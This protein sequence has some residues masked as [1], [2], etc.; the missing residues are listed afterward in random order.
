[1]GKKHTGKNANGQPRIEDI[2]VFL[3][4][5]K[6]KKYHGKAV[7]QPTAQLAPPICRN[8]PSHVPAKISS[9]QGPAAPFWD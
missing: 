2:G 3:L 8:F 9:K 1:M 6:S 7:K 4:K 5:N